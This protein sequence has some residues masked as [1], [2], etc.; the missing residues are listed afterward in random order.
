M[1][2]RDDDQSSCCLRKGASWAG[3][4]SNYALLPITSLPLGENG[5]SYNSGHFPLPTTHHLYVVYKNVSDGQAVILDVIELAYTGLQDC[6]SAQAMAFTSRD[7]YMLSNG[8]GSAC[9]P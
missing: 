7:Q 3:A 8:N 1:H 2:I 9:G 5:L 6:M 4:G